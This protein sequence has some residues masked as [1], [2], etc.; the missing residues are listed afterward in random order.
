MS[1]DDSHDGAQGSL[2]RSQSEG[3]LAL[4]PLPPLNLGYFSSPFEKFLKDVETSE[5]AGAFTLLDTLETYWDSRMDLLER[6]LKSHGEKLKVRANEHLAR[7]KTPTGE[8][9]Y[10]KDIENEV[11]K[12]K[13]TVSARMAS[14]TTAWQSAKVIRTREKVSFFIGVMSI[15]YTSLLVGLAPEWLHVLYT[16]QTLYFLPTRYYTYKKKAWHYFLFDLCY[17]VNVLALLFIWVFPG[18][19]VLW[20]SCYLLTHGSLASAVITWRNSLVFHDIDKVTSLYI[21]IYPPLVFTMICHFYPNAATRF[22]AVTTVMAP[23][24]S[25]FLSAVIYS[26]WQGLYWKLV[27][28][29]RKAKV[30]SGQRTTSF[31]FLLNDKRGVIGRM[32]QSV[33]PQYRLPGFMFGQLVYTV[34]TELPAAFLLYNSPIASVIFLLV[35]FGVSVWNG[36]GFYIEVFGR[37]FEREL[38][39]L[40]KEL[41]ETRSSAA[42]HASSPVATPGHL[43]TDHD[44]GFM[45]SGVSV[46][47]EM[48]GMD[49]ASSEGMGSPIM[50]GGPGKPLDLKEGFKLDVVPNADESKKDRSFTTFS[51]AMDIEEALDCYLFSATISST[52]EF[53]QALIH[54]AEAI[55]VRTYAVEDVIATLLQQKHYL[56][57]AFAISPGWGEDIRQSLTQPTLKSDTIPRCYLDMFTSFKARI[58]G[59]QTILSIPRDLIDIGD[60][61]ENAAAAVSAACLF[62]EDLR[63]KRSNTKR[64]SKSDVSHPIA[65]YTRADCAP[66]KSPD[67]AQRLVETLMRRLGALMKKYFAFLLR[68]SPS[69]IIRTNVM[70]SMCNAADSEADTNAGPNDMSAPED[71]LYFLGDSVPPGTWLI[72]LAQRALGHLKQWSTGN[73]VLY[74]IV[75]RKLKE[76][77]EGQFTPA[78]HAR[79]LDSAFNIP[80]FEAKLVNEIS[81]IY[82]IDCGAPSLSPD[83]ESQY[84]VNKKFWR[85]VSGQLH[86][87]NAEYRR[88]C[89]ARSTPQIKISGGGTIPPLSFYRDSAGSEELEEDVE[90]V[91]FGTNHEDDE[92]FLELHRIM[93]LEKFIP[94]SAEL[95]E[96]VEKNL[97]GTFMFSLSLK[98]RDIIDHR[99]SSL[100]LGRS[101]TGKTTTMLF[102]ILAYEMSSRRSGLQCRQMFVTQSSALA[103]KV[104]AVYDKM[105]RRSLDLASDQND[106]ESPTVPTFTFDDVDTA[107]RQGPVAL[108]DS[109]GRLQDED[110]PLFLSYDEVLD[111]RGF[112]VAHEFKHAAHGKD[113]PSSNPFLE[114]RRS[115]IKRGKVTYRLFLS[116]I[117]PNLGSRKGDVDPLLLFNEIMGVIKGSELALSTSSGYLDLSTYES[118][119]PRA[120]PVFADRRGLIYDLF[121]R[122]LRFKPKGSWDAP[123]R[124]HAIIRKVQTR[125][126]AKLINFVYVDE[127]QDNLLIDTALFRALCPNPHGLFFAGDTAQTVSAGSSFRF[128]DLKA[129][130]YRLERRDSLVVNRRRKPVDPRFFSLAINYRSH[131]G[132]VE[133]AAFLVSALSRFFPGS[134]DILAR[135]Q[136]KLAEG[137]T[138]IFFMQRGE[139]TPFDSFV[140]E[141]GQSEMEFGANQV[142]IVRDELASE[143]LRQR[144]GTDT[145]LVMT[146]YASKGQEFN[147]VLLYN[148]FTDSPATPT[149]WRALLKAG[150]TESDTTSNDILER[151]HA[152]LQTELKCLYVGLTRARKNVWIWDSGSQGESF[153]ALLVRRKLARSSDPKEAPP[154]MGAKSTKREWALRGKECF[155]RE[156]YINASLAFRRA[157]LTWWE[158]VANAYKK[159]A[160]AERLPLRDP[161]RP[162][163]MKDSADDIR[164]CAERAVAAK[165]RERLKAVAANLYLEAKEYRLSADLFYELR[166]YN[167]ATWNYRLAGLFKKAIALINNHLDELNP[168]LVQDVKDVAAVMAAKSLFASAEEHAQFLE[169]N[170]FK[171]QRVAALIDLDQHEAAA[172]VLLK[173]DRQAEAIERLLASGTPEAK[174]KATKCLITGINRHI[175]I[176]SPKTET[177]IQNELS[178][179]LHLSSSLSLDPLQKA[180]VDVA[181]AIQSGD[182]AKLLSDAQKHTQSLPHLAL[183]CLDAHMSITS[184]HPL[185]NH[186]EKIDDV[187]KSLRT[188]VMYGRFVRTVAQLPDLALRGGIQRVFGLSAP[189]ARETEKTSPMSDGVIVLPHSLIYEKAHASAAS[190]QAVKLEIGILVA[191]EAASQQICEAMLSRYNL[192]AEKLSQALDDAKNRAPFTICLSYVRQGRCGSQ[193]CNR[194]HLS[195]ADLSTDGFN[196]RVYLHLLV[197]AAL[198]R[199]NKA[200]RSRRLLQGIWLQRLFETCYPLETL[201]G[202]ISWLKPSLIPDY[203]MLISSAKIWCEDIYRTMR[204]EEQKYFLTNAIGCAMFGS[205]VD[206]Q[207]ATHYIPHGGWIRARDRDKS[208]SQR[209]VENALSWFSR[210]K[211][212]RHS[213]AEATTWEAAFKALIEFAKATPT[214]PLVAL[215]Y[216][217]PYKHQDRATGVRIIR[218]ISDEDLSSKLHFSESALATGSADGQNSAKVRPTVQGNVHPAE[219]TSKEPSISTLSPVEAVSIILR[220][221]RSYKGRAERR[222]KEPLWAAYHERATV[223]RTTSPSRIYGLHLSG[224]MPYVLAYV[225]RLIDRCNAINDDLNEQASKVPHKELDAVR[226]RSR[227]VRPLLRDAKLVAKA[228]EPNAPEHDDLS[229]DYLRAEVAKVPELRARVLAISPTFQDTDSSYQLLEE[230]WFVEPKTKTKRRQ[231]GLNMEDVY[232]GPGGTLA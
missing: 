211:R 219:A 23:W 194:Y 7:M 57:E 76:L 9:Q 44:H 93:A 95:I 209:Y 60:D 48:S 70:R 218:W 58:T 108:P 43:P 80:L 115:E 206:Y 165:D 110:F 174:R 196:K 191:S 195:E 112:E 100:V 73:T 173:M 224:V 6:R 138:P 113:S 160:V 4:P 198:E 127:A 50:I 192:W 61:V 42:S 187:L 64:R 27:L 55:P 149:D 116:Q 34:I 65:V 36:A 66:P 205:A 170:G 29:D 207:N 161:V 137:P 78:N 39:A 119:S 223:L 182:A 84:K 166:R 21:H 140:S 106:I 45:S 87:T 188:Y 139:E 62:L 118:L 71:A 220:Y 175:A 51:H 88:R 153:E 155:Q 91:D 180:E 178:R 30:E 130:L 129:F 177:E 136:A 46:S 217:I 181:R 69:R 135:E 103:E 20:H 172:E 11:K 126:L 25:L 150:L 28:V 183:L 230:F 147:D 72:V 199:I 89:N 104:K 41:A 123:E 132:I 133:P 184:S 117:W 5:W 171:E 59:L 2:S 225:R 231:P 35:I 12:F 159:K 213:F 189:E 200:G 85:S 204:K 33:S 22:P 49:E 186:P 47:S 232:F 98:E 92:S 143:T 208:V 94:F 152:I 40:R 162:L 38:E 19:P 105:K 214:D 13:V 102:K 185:G 179:L 86:K 3:L 156:D 154:W 32:L 107:V 120:Y 15:L 176:G 114:S 226:A 52:D 197:I 168:D 82:Q 158:G 145:A 227:V 67:D 77:H 210:T 31:S 74:E 96:A 81:I 169:E 75:S 142:I 202:S 212:D 157:G 18:S 228:I 54:L 63:S 56:L 203:G 128:N 79:F 24:K 10:S 131:A 53:D 229:L 148:F 190:G 146:I 68:H 193:G 111:H 14:L 97:D 16:V 26:I 101:G 125:P 167:E 37:K 215:V 90:P 151:Q 216:K 109:W 222:L 83:Q 1:S 124:S 8:F 164:Q 134:I 17:Y 99:S 221:Y 121:L 122:Y 163:Y 201:L 144:I 141:S